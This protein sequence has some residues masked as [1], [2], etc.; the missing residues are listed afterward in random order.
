MSRINRP[1]GESLVLPAG[2]FARL[3]SPHPCT[4]RLEARCP[5]PIVKATSR[6]TCFAAVLSCALLCSGCAHHRSH[7]PSS[8]GHEPKAG[9]SIASEIVAGILGCVLESVLEGSDDAVFGVERD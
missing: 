9:N 5:G 4:A 6:A 7:S 3:A 8:T 2:H 1:S